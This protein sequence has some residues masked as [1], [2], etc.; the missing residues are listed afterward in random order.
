LVPLVAWIPH[1]SRGEPLDPVDVGRFNLHP[2][3]LLELVIPNLLAGPPGASSPPA[4]LAF[5]R[6][7]Y[8]S[9]PWSASVHVG[10]ATAALALLAA[11]RS[12][13]ARALL[14][15]AAVVA[16][17]ALGPHAG[18]ARVAQWLPLL[19]RFRFWEKL[20]ALVPM[21]L[22][23]AAALGIV[24]LARAEQRRRF[25]FA[26]GGTGIVLLA[27][28]FA[29]VAGGGGALAAA[30]GGDD[31]AEGARQLVA[32]LRSG[33][34]LSGA[35]LL[36]LAAVAQAGRRTAALAAAVV[37]A[38]L[39]VASGSAWALS[40]LEVARPAAPLADW[41]RSQPG[42]Q[43]VVTGGPDPDLARVGRPGLG[44]YEA[45]A[46]WN[47]RR[48][49]AARNVEARVGHLRNYVALTPARAMRFER[50]RYGRPITTGA[51]LLGVGHAVVPADPIYAARLGV[52]P[53]WPVEAADEEAGLALRALPHRPR[54][55]VA[56]AVRQVDRRGAME[57]LL[58]AD[59]RSD[60]SVV[61]GPLPAGAGRA[62]GSATLVHDRPERATI[63]VRAD[64]PALLV[65]NDAF[66]E[67][68][69]A[70]VDGRPAE[71]LP[72]NYLARGVW[73]SAGAHE[74]VFRYATPGLVAGWLVLGAA[75][76]ALAGWAAWGRLPT[77][78]SGTRRLR[79][80]GRNEVAPPRRPDAAPRGG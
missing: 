79:W 74:V 52:E 18:F 78:P 56:A 32:N 51:G 54:A 64:R 6:D 55:Y 72:A 28:A 36:A 71:I 60:E 35:A 24:A 46:R 37:G 75:A 2:L 66:A 43:R 69:T 34:A 15:A 41:L 44:E 1:S 21:V 4:Y 22:A 27:L 30:L 42:L 20:A 33:L 67:G 65:L 14:A 47:V 59:P 25:A 80:P 38:E 3:R 73:V 8:T 7:P 9:R 26:S 62:D 23:A 5:A 49:E 53:A 11:V 61:E 10:A 50:R 17:M 29:L 39:F 16:W 63:A 31:R 19:S 77:V 48:L 76:L 13:A 58:H 68:W 40:P 70:T 45:Y 57:F 12:R